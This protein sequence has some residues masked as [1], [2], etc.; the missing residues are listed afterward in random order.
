M[1]EVIM[2]TINGD[3]FLLN[4]TINAKEYGYLKELACSEQFK[5]GILSSS[6]DNCEKFIHAAERDLG[7]SLEPVKISYVIRVQ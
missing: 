5:N 4:N 7:I 1:K 6:E 3:I 2:V